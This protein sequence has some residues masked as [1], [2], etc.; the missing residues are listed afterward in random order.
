MSEIREQPEL[1]AA[2]RAGGPVGRWRW[3]LA[4]LVATG[5]IAAAAFP[6]LQKHLGILDNGAWFLDSYAILASSDAVQQGLDPN[7]PNPLDVYNRP[8]RYSSWWLALGRLGLT[9]GDNFLFGVT[10]AG[11][12]F[13]TGWLTLAP[14]SPGELAWS[15]ALLLSPPVLLA[16]NR[17]NNDL[18][19][20]AL[21]GLALWAG[22]K[23]PGLQ[24]SLLAFSVVLAT[25][26]KFYPVVAAGALAAA[27]LTRRH[28]WL[29]AGT[30][31][32]CLLILFQER[33]AMRMAVFP[34]PDG[35]FT[36]G[37]PVLW[38]VLGW[39]GDWVRPAS[40][41]FLVV[42]GGL[43]LRRGWTRGLAGVSDP[44]GE[45]LAFAAGAFMLTGCWL[46]GI[47]FGYRW[48]FGIF[49]AP[50]LWRRAAAG[51]APA[52]IAAV[53]LLVNLWS[54]G[55]YCLVTNL[56]L[57]PRSR[58]GVHQL[59]RYWVALIQAADWVLLA[60]LAGWLAELGLVRLREW[61]DGGFPAERA[62][63]RLPT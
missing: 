56:L 3:W 21:L 61:H 4:L 53:F 12:L 26:L 24:L 31:A 19:V 38:H 25:G 48:I 2:A 9:R 27:A 22:G 23:K 62:P 17:A 40:G 52:R 57:D 35:L 45:R 37:A 32:V 36:F 42:S 58:F 46:A 44:L 41:L 50:W 55:L 49:L 20:F 15:L 63:G 54:D 7:L 60:L 33:A 59:E 39:Q 16:V 13:V 11:L 14:R 29:L 1:T 43:C 47:S 30:L 34:M 8:H 6:G 5:W 18:V 28:R 51:E 10:L